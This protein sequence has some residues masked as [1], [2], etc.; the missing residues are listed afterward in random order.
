MPLAFLA[1][2]CIGPRHH[3][4]SVQEWHP[5]SAM[6]EKYADKNGVVTRA[7]MEAGLRADFAAVDRNHSGCL[8]ENEVRTINEARWKEDQSTASPLIDFRHKGCIDF[9]EYAATPRSLFDQLDT[10]GDG[11]LTPKELHSGGRAAQ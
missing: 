2:A 1:A 6:L 10:N 11:K 5:P 4:A 8:D 7:A 3:P 9:S